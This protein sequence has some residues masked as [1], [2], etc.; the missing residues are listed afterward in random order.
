MIKEGVKFSRPRRGRVVTLALAPHGR[1]EAS[2]SFLR[3]RRLSTPLVTEESLM[4]TKVFSLL[5]ASTIVLASAPGAAAQGARGDWQAVRSLAE[6]TGLLVETKGG[7]TIKSYLGR[8]SD[9]ALELTP[10]GGGAMVSLSRDEVRRV[11]LG[12]K[13][14]K[15]GAAKVGAWIG[16]G[17]GLALAFVVA[18][19]VGENSDAAPGVILFPAYGAGAG[20]LVGAAAGGK[21]RKGRLIYES[22]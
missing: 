15:G 16:A 19:K 13:R 5:M 21:V 8:A 18:A 9:T 22:N 2:C 7:R 3:L 4:R 14:S 1:P 10:M 17:V 11:Y 6:G 20:A 12:K